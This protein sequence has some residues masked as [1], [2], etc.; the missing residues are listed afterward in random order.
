MRPFGS[1][2]VVRTSHSLVALLALC[3][4]CP[5]LDEG[6]EGEGEGE[7]A[8][9][10]S[11]FA[12]P[13]NGA[14]VV[15]YVDGFRVGPDAACADGEL[16]EVYFELADEGAFQQVRASFGGGAAVE[17]VDVAADFD[18]HRGDACGP[19]ATTTTTTVGV[20]V[21]GAGGPS[22]PVCGTVF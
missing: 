9:F 5:S 12:A 2:R 21:T 22:Q 14:L 11:V 15:V 3:V 13:S 16:Y 18:G 19:S 1:L 8:C 6:S 7:E 10:D 17:V 20:Q 4:A